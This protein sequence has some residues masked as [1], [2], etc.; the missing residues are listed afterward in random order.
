MEKWV[1]LV[2]RIVR[3]VYR[4][5]SLLAEARIDSINNVRFDCHMYAENYTAFIPLLPQILQY[6]EFLFYLCYLKFAIYSAWCNSSN[7]SNDWKTTNLIK[8]WPGNTKEINS[9]ISVATREQ[10]IPQTMTFG[11]GT[12]FVLL[13]VVVASL[14]LWFLHALSS[15]EAYY[16]L[17]YTN[18]FFL[19]KRKHNTKAEQNR[20]TEHL[21][22]FALSD[23]LKKWSNI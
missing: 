8:Y 13:A 1:N 14:L 20:T 2:V 11:G 6:I 16:W 19:Q 3:T 17:R 15:N 21:S 18:V 10:S 12:M 5:N 7:I 22:L 23:S 4:I 9:Y